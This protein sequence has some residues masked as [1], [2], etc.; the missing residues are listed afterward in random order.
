MLN[1]VKQFITNGSWADVGVVFA[2]ADGKKFTAFILDRN[3]TGWKRGPEEKKLGI[4][5]SST[6][7][8]ILENC[9]VPVENILGAVGKGAAIA[10][11]VLYVGRYKLGAVTLGGAKEVIKTALQYAQERRQF[12]QPIA[13]FGMLQRKF[14]DM[15]VRAYEG[16]TVVYHTAGSMDEAIGDK[17]PAAAGYYEHLQKAIEDHAI[18]TSVSKVLCSETLWRNVDDGLQILGGYGYSEEYPLA[19]IYRDERINRIFEGT[20][21]INRLIIAGTRSEERRVGKECRSR[22]SPYH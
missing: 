17:A 6:S 4:K 15:L 2:K 8:Y 18:E 7:T 5:G 1:G 12:G 16:D 19:K 11:N 14:A 9:Q 21:E 10:F 20:N 22:W 3:C 13:N